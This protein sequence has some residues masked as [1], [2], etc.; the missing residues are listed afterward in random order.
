VGG[1]TTPFRYW[2]AP[3]RVIDPTLRVFVAGVQRPDGS[4]EPEIVAQH[5]RIDFPPIMSAATARQFARAVMAAADE[6]EAMSEGDIT[7]VEALGAV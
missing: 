7:V 2:E 4:I 3:H 6:M 1:S 5:E